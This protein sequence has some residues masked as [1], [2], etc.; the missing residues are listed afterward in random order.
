MII[1]K[2]FQLVANMHTLILWHCVLD[3][4]SMLMSKAL[5]LVLVLIH[6]LELVM[7]LSITDTQPFHVLVQHI[8]S[9]LF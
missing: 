6:L 4:K 8:G 7:F 5:L 1:V 2:M 3:I 9:Q